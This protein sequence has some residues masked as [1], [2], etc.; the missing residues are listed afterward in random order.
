MARVEITTLDP[1]KCW[2]D[3][4]LHEYETKDFTQYELR[5]GSGKTT[6]WQGRLHLCAGC[7]QYLR[8]IYRKVRN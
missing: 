3:Y 7:K 1:T 5:T 2:C 4:C 8:G 6:Q